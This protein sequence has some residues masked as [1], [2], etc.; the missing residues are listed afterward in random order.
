MN[1][2]KIMA[3]SEKDILLPSSVHTKICKIL[4]LL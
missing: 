3:Q 1:E 2:I 4:H